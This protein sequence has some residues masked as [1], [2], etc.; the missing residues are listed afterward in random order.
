MRKTVTYL[1]LRGL[2]LVALGACSHAQAQA[3]ESP[4]PSAP[5]IVLL[6]DGGMVRGTIT[7]YIRG[8][9]VTI[10]QASGQRRT[11][12]ASEVRYAGPAAG[13]PTASPAAHAAHETAPSAANRI[14]ASGSGE[15]AEPLVTVRAEKVDVH[16][17]QA[18]EAGGAQAEPLTLFL[19]TATAG[20]L[21][22]FTRVC[23][24]PCDAVFA[25]G[26]YT[27][28]LASGTKAALEVKEV[29]E[30]RSSATLVGKYKR[31]AAIRIPL[32][33]VGALLGVGGM[34][35]L[36]GALEPGPLIAGG[37]GMGV[38]VISFATSF[39]FRDQALLT[40]R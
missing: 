18:D 2:L 3:V 16:F 22:G 1:A 17:Q 21:S 4:P 15:Q 35:V 36:F 37:V 9:P 31:R 19:K 39:A 7:E 5:D 13:V 33:V 40:F 10:T 26:S 23:T 29:T 32:R 14:G 11:F 8:Q 12:Q 30:L 38:G 28:A 6:N 24:A 27:F 34:G 25:A 20:N